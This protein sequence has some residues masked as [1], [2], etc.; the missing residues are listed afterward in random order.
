MS[1]RLLPVLLVLAAALS[2]CSSSGVEP[3]DSSSS[4]V[5]PRV[6]SPA[7]S[8]GRFSRYVALGDSYSAG[9]LIPTTDLAGGCARSDHNYPSLVAK[10]LGVRT[11]VD[12]T[13]SGATTADV[14]HVQRTFG[15]ARIPPQGRMLTPDTDL[16]TIGIGGERPDAVQHPGPAVHAAGQ[17]R[18]VGVAVHARARLP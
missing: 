1:R 11:L 3:S 12:V 14:T 4:S 2:A 17:D 6:A 5:G 10:G 7:G 18:P 8:P 9:P 13:C 15:D 16:V